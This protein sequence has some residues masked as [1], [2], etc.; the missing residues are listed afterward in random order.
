MVSMA[1]KTSG[2]KATSLVEIE[3]IFLIVNKREQP[4]SDCQLEEHYGLNTI[5]V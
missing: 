3:G 5:D 2:S 4:H 1:L